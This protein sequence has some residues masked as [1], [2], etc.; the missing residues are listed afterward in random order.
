MLPLLETASS[1][2]CPQKPSNGFLLTFL[3]E[4]R[5]I[6]Q[7]LESNIFI[8][9]EKG[10][11]NA[12]CISNVKIICMVVGGNSSYMYGSLQRKREHHTLIGGTELAHTILLALKM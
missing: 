7:F 10:K 12:K 5:K 9:N 6:E 4:R 2:H 8:S 11:A 3:T 1:H